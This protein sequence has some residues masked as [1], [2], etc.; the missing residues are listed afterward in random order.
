MPVT[1]DQRPIPASPFDEKLG[2]EVT[3]WTAERVRGR[4]PVNGNT[5]IIGLWHGGAS[6]TMIE[7]LGS[8]AATAHAGPDRKAVGTELNVSHLRS[9]REGWVC[10]EAVAVH[11]GGTSAVYQIDL[12]DDA[13]RHLATGR[14]SCRILD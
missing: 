12:T 2:L 7:S 6:A 8:L 9:A 5:Q 10:G 4:A 3:E 14:L 11:L 13:G 1:I